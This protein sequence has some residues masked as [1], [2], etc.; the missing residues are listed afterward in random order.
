M[1][2]AGTTETADR[3]RDRHTR[4]LSTAAGAT[5]RGRRPHGRG[6]DGLEDRRGPQGPH[7]EG[8]AVRLAHL[9]RGERGAPRVVR[10]GPAPRPAGA[11]GAERHHAD[12]GR[13]GGRGGRGR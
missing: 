1:K 6:W 8:E 9:R 2:G 3:T 13:G 12:R 5:P 7:R 4:V 11:F 10:A